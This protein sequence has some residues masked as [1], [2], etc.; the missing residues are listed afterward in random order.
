M[1]SKN[2]LYSFVITYC[3]FMWILET[4]VYIYTVLYILQKVSRIKE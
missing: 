1:I 3:T 4:T 2:V